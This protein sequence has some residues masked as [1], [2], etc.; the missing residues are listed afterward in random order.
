MAFAEFRDAFAIKDEWE[1]LAA[2][3]AERTADA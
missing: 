2:R 1:K 3:F